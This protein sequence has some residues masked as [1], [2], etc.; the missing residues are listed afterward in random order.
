MQ[1]K[2]DNIR[3]HKKMGGGPLYDIGIYCINAAR[4]LFRDEPWE[5]FCTTVNGTDPRFSEVEEMASV[6]LRFPKERL[7]SFSC[8]FGAGD[9]STYRVVGTEGQ[10]VVVRE[11]LK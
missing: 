9:V 6:V 2:P 1:V 10:L 8:S 5:V 3:L 4:Y 11:Q 7:A